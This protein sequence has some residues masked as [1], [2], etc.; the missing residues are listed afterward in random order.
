MQTQR[1]TEKDID[2]GRV[3]IPQATKVMFP[4]E[5]TT[6]N[7]VVRGQNLTCK[8]NPRVGPDKERSGVLLVG[9][10]LLEALV[11][12]DEILEVSSTGSGLVLN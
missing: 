1:I 12:P 4:Q 8:W 6:L 9:K 2:G 11:K 7:L 3:R 5:A 10:A